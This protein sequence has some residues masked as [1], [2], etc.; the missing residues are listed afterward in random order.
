MSE[1]KVRTKTMADIYDAL[2]HLARVDVRN[3]EL[4]MEARLIRCHK[5]PVGRWNVSIEIPEYNVDAE[6][7]IVR[8]IRRKYATALVNVVMARPR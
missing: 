8:A 1:A 7:A 3:K 2:L 5:D 6:K 4:Y